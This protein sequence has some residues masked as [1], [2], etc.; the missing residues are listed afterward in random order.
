MTPEEV[1]RMTGIRIY[2]DHL[3]KVL[4]HRRVTKWQWSARELMRL[5]TEGR[6]RTVKIL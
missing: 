5:V 1:E 6:V 3:N 2:Q 4:E